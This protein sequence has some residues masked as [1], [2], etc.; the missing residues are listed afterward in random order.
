MKI[1]L[2]CQK[3][4]SNLGG[5][6]RYSRFLGKAL[7]DNGHRVH[8]FANRWED[9]PGIAF[10]SVPI[11]RISSPGK[12]LSFA[13]A[14]NK[15]LARHRFDVIHSMERIWYQD[16]YRA[17]DGINPVQIA[18]NYPSPLI[19]ALKRMGPRRRALQLLENRIYRGNGCRFIMTNSEL[20]KRQ[21]IQH[22]AVDP[23]RIHVIYNSVDTSRF[24]PGLRRRH[25]RE[26]RQ[27]FGIGENQMVLLFVSNNFKLKGLQTL[28]QATAMLSAMDTVLL[29]AGHDDPG[30]YRERAHRSGLA[31]RV[32]FLGPIRRIE[33]FYG[34]ADILVLPT[35]YDPFANVCLEAMASGLPVITTTTNGASEVIRNGENGFTIDPDDPTALAESIRALAPTE[36]RRRMGTA[37]AGAAG[38][39]SMAAHLARVLDLYGGVAGRN[40]SAPP[41]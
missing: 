17:S 37:G 33:P 22:Y 14:A 16:I 20:I 26:I 3:Y 24:H 35:R 27:R 29:V 12:N 13:Y 21:I 19:R 38:A 41:G 36:N 30:P 2:I 7:L 34:T 10:H 23:D 1:A 25:R 5:L 9:E 6:E 15:R 40:P 8:V 39:F 32:R 28:L 18:R 31:G 11:L 4:T